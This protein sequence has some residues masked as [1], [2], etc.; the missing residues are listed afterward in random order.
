MKKPIPLPS[1][2]RLREL[3]DYEPETGKF[4]RRVRVNNRPVGS[5]TKPVACGY[6]DQG[7]DG[8]KYRAHRL[9]WRYVTGEDPG[10][11]EVDHRNRNRADNS[12]SNLRIGTRKQNQENRGAKGIHWHKPLMKW[13]AQI[14]HHRKRINLGYFECPLMARLAYEDAKKDMHSWGY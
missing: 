3:F 11:L 6:L 13:G 10:A 1:Q 7:V 8:K 5:T 9:I 14:N 4:S 12:W 2:E